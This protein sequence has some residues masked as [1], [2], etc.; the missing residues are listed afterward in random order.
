MNQMLYKVPTKDILNEFV[1]LPKNICVIGERHFTLW[2]AASDLYYTVAVT[3]KIFQWSTIIP[4]LVLFLK[5][6]A[7]IGAEIEIYHHNTEEIV[8]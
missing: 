7:T 1:K 5:K 3:S 4:S 2:Y 8:G 6:H